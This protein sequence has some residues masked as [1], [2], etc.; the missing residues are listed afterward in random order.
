MDSS[1]TSM[2]DLESLFVLSTRGVATICSEPY[3]F[4]ISTR[5]VAERRDRFSGSKILLDTLLFLVLPLAR[6]MISIG[7][8]YRSKLCCAFQELRD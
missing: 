5:M 8:V 1:A 3:S 4:P 7:N 2:F 6:L